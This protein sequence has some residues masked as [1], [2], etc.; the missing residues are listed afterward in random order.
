MNSSTGFG[1]L[2]S[3]TL[4]GMTVWWSAEDI[5]VFLNTPGFFI[6][7]SWDHRRDPHQ[8]SDA[9]GPAGIALGRNPVQG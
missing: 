6:L 5:A 8:L 3:P 4:L 9:R 1:I 2:V 7:I